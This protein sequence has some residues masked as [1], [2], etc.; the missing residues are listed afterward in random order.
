[1]PTVSLK[2]KNK[3]ISLP[4]IKSPN[5][6]PEEWNKLQT[7][8]MGMQTLSDLV[9]AYISYRPPL[10]SGGLSHLLLLLMSF[11]DVC[12]CSASASCLLPIPQVSAEMPPPQRVLLKL[13]NLNFHP[14]AHVHTH[15]HSFY[16]TAQF[17]SWYLHLSQIICAYSNISTHVSCLWGHMSHPLGP[18]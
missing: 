9:S 7:P 6:F 12:T 10:L 2:T 18:P 17:L 8:Y 5:G 13:H 1:M 16:P 15:T 3:I 11:Q 14:C 4:C